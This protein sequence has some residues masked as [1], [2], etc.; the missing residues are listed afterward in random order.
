MNGDPKVS[1]A[2]R[3]VVGH[4][5]PAP[6]IWY[7]LVSNQRRDMPIRN[8]LN[9]HQF[10]FRRAKAPAPRTSSSG[11]SSTPRPLAPACDSGAEEQTPRRDRTSCR[12]RRRLPH[13]APAE[14]TARAIGVP[15]H[16]SL[17]GGVRGMRGR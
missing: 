8:N 15:E 16:R 14:W 13:P 1:A 2:D 11:K 4:S 10:F 17:P 7:F 5:C 6:L 12:A 9:Q 3:S